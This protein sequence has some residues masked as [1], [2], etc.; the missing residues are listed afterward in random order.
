MYEPRPEIAHAWPFTSTSISPE[1]ERNYSLSFYFR[2]VNLK[3]L[4]IRTPRETA[5]TIQS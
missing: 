3:F 2:V 4:A 5:T 1:R